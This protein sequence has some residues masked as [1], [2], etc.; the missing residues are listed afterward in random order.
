[1]WAGEG[2]KGLPSAINSDVFILLNVRSELEGWDESLARHSSL[3]AW[4]FCK[5]C[6]K[7]A[8]NRGDLDKTMTRWVP[9]TTGRSDSV[10]TNWHTRLTLL[11]QLTAGADTWLVTQAHV[12]VIITNYKVYLFKMYWDCAGTGGN[13]MK[14]VNTLLINF[15]A[16][17]TIT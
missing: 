8:L 5:I 1:M 7:I 16:R 11:T 9:R 17:L 12:A 14:H 13:N 10:R 2:R 15:K 4:V 6:S 3:L